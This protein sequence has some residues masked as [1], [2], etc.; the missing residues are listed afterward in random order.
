MEDLQLEVTVVEEVEAE[1]QDGSSLSMLDLFLSVQLARLF[2][3]VEM[4]V[5]EA[6]GETVPR[7]LD[8]VVLEE[9]E[10]EE[11]ELGEM[12][13]SSFSHIT[14]FQI[15]DRLPLQEVQLVQEVQEEPVGMVVR[16]E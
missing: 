14:N 11:E 8:Q 3:T 2:P 6:M 5:P 12:V 10:E 15:A 1:V 4:V 16:P 7:E 9:E 13:E